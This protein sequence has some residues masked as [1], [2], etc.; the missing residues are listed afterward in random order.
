V[1]AESLV[2]D[3]RNIYSPDMMSGLGFQYFSI[4]R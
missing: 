2:F 1:V 4:G 3:G